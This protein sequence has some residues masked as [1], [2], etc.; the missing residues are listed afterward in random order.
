MDIKETSIA[1]EPEEITSEASMIHQNS[2][3]KASES[4]KS[5][6]VIQGS[7][8]TS[9]VQPSSSCCLVSSTDPQ[10]SV[11]EVKQGATHS[12]P[13]TSLV[14][15]SS[16]CY[17][18]SSTDLQ[19]NVAEVREGA[20]HTIASDMHK[21]EAQV[22]ELYD[23]STRQQQTSLPHIVETHIPCANEARIAAN[24]SSVSE[25][26]K[27]E[28]EPG[29]QSIL[30]SSSRSSC[31]ILSPVDEL[32]ENGL[33]LNCQFTPGNHHLT[34]EMNGDQCLQESHASSL[35]SHF[36]ESAITNLASF[37]KL[38]S[39][40]K[41][42]ANQQRMSMGVGMTFPSVFESFRTSIY[43]MEKYA[44]SL[45][46][47][48]D[49]HMSLGKLSTTENLMTSRCPESYGPRTVN[50][51]HLAPT[52]ELT[53]QGPRFQQGISEKV[54]AN[55]FPMSPSSSKG[56]PLQINNIP[57]HEFG[58]SP[59]IAVWG[60]AQETC[61]MPKISSS[62]HSVVHPFNQ[63]QGKSMHVMLKQD[64]EANKAV[65]SGPSLKI[66]TN[67]QVVYSYNCPGQTK[68]VDTS[69][70]AQWQT[71]SVEDAKIL[72]LSS[73]L[74]ESK[75]KGEEVPSRGF[76]GSMPIQL[77]KQDYN[78]INNEPL[79]SLGVNDRSRIIPH[80]PK[81][82]VSQLGTAVNDK[83]LSLQV[84]ATY[85]R[86]VSLGISSAIASQR[87]FPRKNIHCLFQG[88]TLVPVNSG[89]VTE[90][91][92]KESELKVSE[93]ISKFASFSSNK[94]EC[95]QQN[96][97]SMENVGPP[98]SVLPKKRKRVVMPLLPWHMKIMDPGGGIPTISASE[99]AWAAVTN[100]LVEKDDSD[101]LF[102]EKVGSTS[103]AKQRLKLI[104]QLTQQLVPPLPSALMCGKTIFELESL[105]YTLAKIVL[106]NACKLG[107][108]LRA[109][110]DHQKFKR[111]RCNY[112]QRVEE[113]YMDKVNDLE[114]E[115]RRLNTSSYMS[116]LR[117]E[118]QDLDRLLLTNRLAK[119]HARIF[120]V[121][122]KKTIKDGKESLSDCGLSVNKMCP[123]RY[124]TAIPMPK[125]IPEGLL[126]YSL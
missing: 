9:L 65:T 17:L 82:V 16:S 107:Y 98:V 24:V 87:N 47:T 11:V 72:S 100:R 97:P 62:L 92:A 71:F 51:H 110:Q 90:V 75:G 45:P 42:L 36:G 35:S 38:L 77:Q 93:Q 109:S 106:A 20:T 70:P 21:F 58:S 89:S 4:D 124:V 32:K 118:S 46:S 112:F 40:I 103:R 43:Q 73:C 66:K 63:E 111:L 88:A 13:I 6:V 61:S 86:M 48:S 120:T 99:L 74:Q 119:H 56:L 79:S 31:R 91:A 15:P 44:Q 126:C 41:K 94:N 69:S 19:K 54:V 1:R 34:N 52:E 116:E 3:L 12:S 18:V 30:S 57:P 115:L 28:K 123:H 84:A 85:Q 101:D 96:S 14:Q 25:M 26:V 29:I 60:Q 113:S 108:K 80:L 104:S 33:G 117:S 49:S 7:P 102:D 50:I 67:Q 8:I 64:N 76:I 125:D 10:K 81:A 5:I 121:G 2:L 37:S 95:I 114:N 23:A 68:V 39:T 59:S 55:R 78:H 27:S 122:S 105:I 53:M 83:L 22:C